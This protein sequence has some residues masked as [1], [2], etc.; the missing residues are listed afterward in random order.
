MTPH[1]GRNAWTRVAS[2]PSDSPCNELS[3]G[4]RFSLCVPLMG[5]LSLGHFLVVHSFRPASNGLDSKLDNSCLDHATHLPLHH[6]C[7]HGSLAISTCRVPS[8]AHTSPEQ[9]ARICALVE[10]GQSTTQVAAAAEGVSH[11]TV[12]RIRQRATKPTT[13][14]PGLVARTSFPS[15]RNGELSDWSTSARRRLMWWVRLSK[16][17]TMASE[18]T[19]SAESSN[20]ADPPVPGEWRSLFS[21]GSTAWP[22]LALP[23][24][25]HR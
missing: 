5:N 14:C 10:C 11:S 18:S 23:R 3:M 19:P 24:C 21:T 16:R 20:A 17:A 12:V 1:L 22:L 13:T 9:R 6:T 4:A 25:G 2:P 8:M 7:N 15:V